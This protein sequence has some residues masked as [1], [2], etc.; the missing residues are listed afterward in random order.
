LDTRWNAWLGLFPYPPSW[1]TEAVETYLNRTGPYLAARP[2][3]DLLEPLE[4]A[5]LGRK[6]EAYGK[7]VIDDQRK[8]IWAH[9]V[10]GSVNGASVALLLIDATFTMGLITTAIGVTSFIRNRLAARA[11]K[12]RKQ[13]LRVFEKWIAELV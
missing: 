2:S 10:D 5:E 3:P 9:I 12:R 4:R 11:W 13:Q 7:K 8:E 1:T 6:F